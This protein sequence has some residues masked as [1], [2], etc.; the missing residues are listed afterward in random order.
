MERS[1]PNEELYQKWNTE[2]PGALKD[3]LVVFALCMCVCVVGKVFYCSVQYMQ[4]GPSHILSSRAGAIPLLSF[5][6]FSSA[7]VDSNSILL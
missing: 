4:K 6:P 2:M 3:K 5:F 1:H 7:A